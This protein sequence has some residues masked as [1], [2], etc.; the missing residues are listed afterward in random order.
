M[1]LGLLR[2]TIVFGCFLMLAA[3]QP[4]IARAQQGL[5]QQLTA[6][7][8]RIQHDPTAPPKY[9]ADVKLHVRLRFFPWISVTLHGNE[10]YKHPGI[11]HFVF[12]GVPK[13]AEHFSDLAY[14]LGDSS[15]W[16]AKYNISLLTAPAPN[17]E[18]VIRLVP[19]HRGMVKALDV[20]VDGVKGHILRAVW[21]RYDGGSITLVQH[22][23]AIGSREVVDLQN[24]SI[25]I[26]GMKADLEAEYSAFAL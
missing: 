24:A 12:R 19:K 2:S 15:T 13:A 17:V 3:A 22:F 1:R 5:D 21:S 20:T 18:P 6:L 23:N 10:A 9:T 14:D 26:P 8:T 11:Y 25:R 7:L 16:P 4:P